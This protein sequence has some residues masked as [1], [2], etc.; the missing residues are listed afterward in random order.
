MQV[1]LDLSK[2]FDRIWHKGFLYKQECSGI[3]GKLL[4]LI[5]TYLADCKQ[6]VFLN[7]KCSEWVPICAGVPQGSVLGPLS[8]HIYVQDLIINLKCDV[9][10]F[11]DDTFLFKVVDDVG[12]SADEINADLDK[13]QL[14]AWQWNM[15][16][17]ANKT[18]EV[19]FS[20]KK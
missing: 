4:T 6:G 5:E 7:G 8:F 17:N 15:Q 13:V 12:R 20:C 1:F 9:K 11:A 16:F 18:K 10:I 19:V 3:N 2:T 14:W